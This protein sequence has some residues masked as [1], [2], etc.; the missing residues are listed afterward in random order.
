M[1]NRV[2][3]F[4]LISLLVDSYLEANV[5]QRMSKSLTQSYFPANQANLSNPSPPKIRIVLSAALT[6][7]HYEFRK[8]Q[9]IEAFNTLEKYGYKDVYVVE[10]LKQQGPTFL[11]TYTK[12]VFYSSVNDPK[13]KNNG[14]NEARTLLEGIY[15]FNFGPD[16]MIIKLTG[17]YRL[18]S[19]YFLQLV[20]DNPDYDVFIKFF[21]RNEPC[22]MTFCFAMRCKFFQEMYEQMDYDAME[23]QWIVAEY[24]V[25]KYIVRKA[26]DG[27]CRVFLCTKI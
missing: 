24:E 5:L 23:S 21:E 18:L 27:K 16:D 9:Y 26:N 7:A 6:D 19:S 17:R 1:K 4:T 20:H 12:N 3:L 8:Q 25:A 14:I 15:H 11:D 22:A 13:F 2:I 10:A